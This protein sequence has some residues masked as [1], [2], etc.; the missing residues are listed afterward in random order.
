VRSGRERIAER[1]PVAPFVRQAVD[2]ATRTAVSGKD[3]ASPGIALDSLDQVHF[4]V[5]HITFMITD[6]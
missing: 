5:T 1:R 6:G 4:A 3:T 2:K